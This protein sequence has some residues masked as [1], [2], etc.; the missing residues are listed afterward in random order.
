M[1][2]G[3]QFSKKVFSTGKGTSLTL[4]IPRD[5]VNLYRVKNGD[6]LTLKILYIHKKEEI[7]KKDGK[8]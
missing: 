8:R 7:E 1:E 6:I 4:T 2:I 3:E 5:I